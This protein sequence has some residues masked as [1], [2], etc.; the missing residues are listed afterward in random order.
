MKSDNKIS[1]SEILL[2]KPFLLVLTLMVVIAACSDSSIN[3]VDNDPDEPEEPEQL[4]P[5]AEHS[6]DGPVFDIAATGNGTILV[7]DMGTV[8]EIDAGGVNEFTDLPLVEGP[9]AFGEPEITFINGLLPFEDGTFYASRSSLDLAAGSGLLFSDG[10]NTELAADIEAFTMGDWPDGEP[11]HAPSWK[12]FDCEPPGGYS[13][14]PF[15]NPYNLVALS[16]DEIL[17][18]DAGAN[19]LLS[20]DTNG[21]I[22][23]V[24]VFSP[25][26]SPDTGEPLV[27]FPLDQDTNC[28][29]E[30]VSASVAIGPDGAYYVGE[31]VGSTAEN[32][33]GQPTPEGIASVWRIEPGSR[34][35]VCPSDD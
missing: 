22:E 8:R 13:A 34:N 4:D 14:A 31:L 15:S 6:F 29:V 18:A 9:G 19:S 30:P 28:P 3:S 10:T 26:I 17:L 35:V 21:N 24:A 2:M 25:I 11:G 16:D 7:A 33:G 27:Q 32:F 5:A 1:K 12:N 23:V 20:I